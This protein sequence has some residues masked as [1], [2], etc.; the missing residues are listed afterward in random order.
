MRRCVDL[1]RR[2]LLLL[3]IAAALTGASSL[4]PARAETSAASGTGHDRPPSFELENQPLA[5]HRV[6]LLEWAYEAV[7]T[8]PTEPHLKPRARGRHRV[9]RAW[10]KLDQPERAFRDAHA[11]GNWR[12]AACYAEYALYA[13]RHGQEEGFEPILAFAESGARAA[14]QQWRQEYVFARIAKTYL[15]LG[16]RE[17]AAKYD[18]S[19]KSPSQKGV[20]EKARA[21][22][23]GDVEF[24]G[25][26]KKLDKMIESGQFG[27]I[28]N[29]ADAYLTLYDNHYGKTDRRQMIEQ[30][31]RSAYE[32]MPSPSKM[33]LFLKLARIAGRHNDQKQAHVF[34]DEAGTIAEAR[35]WRVSMPYRYQYMAR[36]AEARHKAGDTD[37]AKTKLDQALAYYD[38]HRERMS[39]VRYANAL[40]PLAE[41][42]HA[43]GAQA[44]A[45]QVYGRAIEEG[46][47][48]P[49]RRPVVLDLGQTCVSLALHNVKPDQAL[50]QALRDVKAELGASS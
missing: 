4:V 43:I 15:V 33:D 17:K 16:N 38:K 7:S 1:R 26:K 44:K 39:S 35:D 50:W 47:I 27:S 9:V 6:K 23:T 40:R 32:E 30:R 11:I 19:L 25:L 8:L 12:R 31:I 49:N 2:G 5:S 34:V 45:R 22:Q 36:L 37:T 13:A 10:L 28:R 21:E 29:A 14:S 42:Y 24:E 48:N 46:S 18:E 41:A 20:L 3:G